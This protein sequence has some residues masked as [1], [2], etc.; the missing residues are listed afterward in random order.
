[1]WMMEQAYWEQVHHEMESMK[2]DILGIHVQVENLKEDF[3][4]ATSA[5]EGLQETVTG[6]NHG[7]PLCPTVA[8]KEAIMRQLPSINGFNL[9]DLENSC[10][11]K[12]W[13]FG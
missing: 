2:A 10:V 7:I 3:P 1:M 8:I 5:I 12:E 4:M 6:I 11:E 9:S 13:V